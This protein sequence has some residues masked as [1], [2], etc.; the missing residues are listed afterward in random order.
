REPRFCVQ[1]V[2]C[3]K[4]QGAIKRPALGRE[5]SAHRR[6]FL[7][8]GGGPVGLER[9][10]SHQGFLGRRPSSADLG[11]WRPRYLSNGP[12]RGRRTG[13]HPFEGRVIASPS[14]SPRRRSASTSSSVC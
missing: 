6:P 14:G 7:W 11:S 10:T 8:L 5:A 3:R 4:A 13:P 9:A 12:R 1:L 2:S